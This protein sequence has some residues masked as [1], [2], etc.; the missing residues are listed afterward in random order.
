MKIQ[1]ADELVQQFFIDDPTTCV[2]QFIYDEK[3]SVDTYILQF[4][5]A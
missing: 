4:Y 5:Y 2:Y 1:H 3:E